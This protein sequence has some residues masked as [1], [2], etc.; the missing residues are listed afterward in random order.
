MKVK[1]FLISLAVI[2][3][4]GSRA[5]SRSSLVMRA[6][7]GSFSA[8]PYEEQLRNLAPVYKPRGPNQKTYTDLL[9][10]ESVSVLL[11]IGPAG[12]GKTLFA[13]ATAVDALQKGTI[14]KIVLTRPVV[15]VEEDIGYLP[16]NMIMKMNPNSF[17]QS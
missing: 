16:G 1:Q 13:C 9:K 3:F 2:P 4:L 10:N 7:K 6:K 14:Q 12:T 15:S 5:Y 17:I 8:D 11:G